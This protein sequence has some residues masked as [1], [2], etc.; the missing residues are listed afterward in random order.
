AVVFLRGVDPTAGKPWDLPEV[1]VEIGN[2]KIEVVQGQHRGGVGFVRRG[3]VVNLCSKEPSYH[4][5]RGR[6]NDFFSATLPEPNHNVTRR[7]MTPGL[8]ELSSGTGQYWAHGTLFVA[9]HPY[10]TVTDADGR[11]VLDQIPA[12]KSELVVWLPNWNAKRQER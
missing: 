12:G 8:V 4:V 7:L 5:I 9:E 6:G 10:F 3:A 11:F 1:S 2:G